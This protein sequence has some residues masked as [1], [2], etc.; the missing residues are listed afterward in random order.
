MNKHRMLRS[1][2]SIVRELDKMKVEFTKNSALEK[3]K[4]TGEIDYTEI[5]RD[6]TVIRS[7][8]N[9]SEE[10]VVATEIIMKSK[11]EIELDCEWE[12]KTPQDKVMKEFI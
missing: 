7:L 1:M 2:K 12:G 5:L 3:A 4:K 10:V 6:M 8:N 11:E 9:I